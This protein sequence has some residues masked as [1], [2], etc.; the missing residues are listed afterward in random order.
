V[1]S[2]GFVAET[3]EEAIE[4]LW[5]HAQAMYTRIGRERGWPPT[6]RAGFEADVARGAW[7]VG[8]PETV[9]RKIARTLRVLDADRFTMKYSAGTLPHE[10]L[11]TSIELF[12]T[13]VVP[14]V[15]ELLAEE[16]LV[17]V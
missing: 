12:G 13:Q 10:R 1:H 11:M 9:A 14:R 17:A 6:T 16:A 5:P 8:A 2:P 7:H 15:R 3:D 4:V